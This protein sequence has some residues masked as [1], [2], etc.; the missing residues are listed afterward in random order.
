MKD[1]KSPFRS[2]EGL[3][4]KEKK[5]RKQFAESDSNIRGQT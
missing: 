5:R 3:T 1:T 2:W 4:E